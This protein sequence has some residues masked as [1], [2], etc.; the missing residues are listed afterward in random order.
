M[1]GNI[2]YLGKNW[3][4]WCKKNHSHRVS[5]QIFP[6]KGV[7]A[8]TSVPGILCQHKKSTGSAS[9]LLKKVLGKTSKDYQTCIYSYNKEYDSPWY[10]Q[11]WKFISVQLAP[12]VAT[13]AAWPVPAPVAQGPT[14]TAELPLLALGRHRTRTMRVME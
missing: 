2:I 14:R 6:L 12:W 4:K 9:Y 5:G 10:T 13:T 7:V 8:R 1:G 3:I 11:T